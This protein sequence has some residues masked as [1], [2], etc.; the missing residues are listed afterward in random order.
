MYFCFFSPVDMYYTHI[1]N[2]GSLYRERFDFSYISFVE[3][4]Y[5]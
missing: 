5:V 3:N 4:K 2:M 1:S